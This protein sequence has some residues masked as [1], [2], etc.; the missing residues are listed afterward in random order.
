MPATEVLQK[1]MRMPEIRIKAEMLGINPGKM[2]KTELIHT[3][4]QAEGHT[5]CFGMSDGQCPNTDCCFSKD[6]LSVK[7]KNNHNIQKHI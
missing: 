7:A 4:Q 5:P 2:K 3:I 6:C 1:C